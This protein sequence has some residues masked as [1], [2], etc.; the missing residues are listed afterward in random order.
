M[1]LGC[2]PG[3]LPYEFP[4]NACAGEKR[5]YLNS[6]DASALETHR[7][8]AAMGFAL[9]NQLHDA[10]RFRINEGKQTSTPSVRSGDGQNGSNMQMFDPRG[11]D[12]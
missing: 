2:A 6:Q 10:A 3:V 8:A 5:E 9:F 7:R 4:W 1:E 11:A 12:K